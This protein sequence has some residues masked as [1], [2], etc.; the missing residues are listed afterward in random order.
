MI[1]TIKEYFEA[2]GKMVG[3]K[4]A[5]GLSTVDDALTY[6]YLVKDVLGGEWLN[7]RYLR[8][9]TSRLAEK[10]RDEIVG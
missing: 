3:F 8:F 10:V 9:G 4:P 1:D 2:T 5:G 6:Y 7:S